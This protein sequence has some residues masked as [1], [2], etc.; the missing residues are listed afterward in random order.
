V[1]CGTPLQATDAEAC[2]VCLAKPP[3][4]GRTRAAVVYDELTRSL[5]LRLKYGRKVAIARTMARYMAPLIGSQPAGAL[6]VPVPLHRSRLWQRGFNQSAIVARELSRNS[7]IN[8][9]PSLLRRV[10]RT[11]PL[12]GMSLQQRRRVVAGAFK[13]ADRAA[14]DGRTV[15]LLD[16][17]LMGLFIS[18]PP[19]HVACVY[20]RGQGVLKKVWKPGLHLNLPFWQKAKLFNVQTLEYEIRKG[21]DLSDPATVGDEAIRAQ[22]SDNDEVVIQ[23]TIL[24]RLDEAEVPRV[25]QEVGEDYVEKIIRYYLDQDPILNNVP[26]YVCAEPDQLA[27]VLDHLSELV[28]K[29]TDGAGGYG[30]LVGPHSSAATCKEFAER[31]KGN[32]RGYIAQPTLSLSRVP[33]II[34]DRIESRHVDLRPF[35]LYGREVWVQPGG[36][37]RVALK[38]GSLVVNSSQGGGSKDTWVLAE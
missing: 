11:P 1:T 22:E 4:I 13:V 7:G 8:S 26:T 36:L 2:P 25:W 32:P 10:R 38:K 5:A 9:D 3:R 21:F 17:V 20:D 19:G 24:F 12:K 31:V 33:T 15:I 18:V 28:V 29:A 35:A 34:S 30:M 27:Y 14:I 23:G 37:T 16:D 6:L